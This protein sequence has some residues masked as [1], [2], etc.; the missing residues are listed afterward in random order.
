MLDF[1][2]VMSAFGKVIEMLD[3]VTI[4]TRTYDGVTTVVSLLNMLEI[5]FGVEVV[6]TLI[7]LLTG[8]NKEVTR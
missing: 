6:L 3:N 2:V 8:F 7:S 1:T 4:F 5:I